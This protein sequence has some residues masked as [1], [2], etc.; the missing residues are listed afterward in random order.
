MMHDL[1]ED[2]ENYLDSIEFGPKEMEVEI[3]GSEY[4]FTTEGGKI[5]GRATVVDGKC[6]EWETEC[7]HLKVLCYI[8][9][10]G[11]WVIHHYADPFET[12]VRHAKQLFDYDHQF[13]QEIFNETLKK[14][15]VPNDFEEVA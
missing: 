2:E 6:T 8:K 4:K 3:E 7:M 14:N 1:Y 9:K 12:G 10:E 5:L 13:T 15:N 11:E